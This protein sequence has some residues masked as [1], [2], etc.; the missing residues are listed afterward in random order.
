MAG[1]RKAPV[2]VTWDRDR[3][4]WKV[5]SAGADRAA[6]Y[7]DTKPEARD[8]AQDIARARRSEYI[9]HRQDNGRIH[10]RD[11]YGHDPYPPEG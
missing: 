9:G 8:R 5:R 11:T 10:E 1:N 4:Q 3:E 2:H 7:F 6:G